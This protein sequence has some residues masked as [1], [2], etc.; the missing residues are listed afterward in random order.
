MQIAARVAALFGLLCI[1]AAP[2]PST[3]AP[4]APGTLQFS[5]TS[6]EVDEGTP[7]LVVAV[8]RTNGSDG[9]VAA[10]VSTSDI[11]AL[12]NQDYTPISV[13]VVFVDGDSTAKTISIPILDDTL[14]EGDQPLRLSL[15]APSGGALLGTHSTAVVTIIDDEPPPTPPMLSVSARIK[16]LRFSWT[17][18]VGASYYKLSRSDLGTPGQRVA[19]VPGNVSS[20][21]LDIAVHRLNWPQAR[22]RLSACNPQGCT[23][24]NDIDVVNQ[25]LGAIGYFKAS[26]T[27]SG[28]DFGS[29]V[30]LS[31]DGGTLAVG[32]D[33]ERSDATGID[34][35][36]N[37]NNEPG[38][39]AVYIFVRGAGG[40]WSQQ[41][42][43][44]A[45]SSSHQRFGSDVALS[46][47]G[48]TL[49]VGARS[50]SSVAL[51]SGA[52]YVFS[53]LATQWSQQALLRP[54]NNILDEGEFGYAVALSADGDTLAVGAR[55]EGATRVCA[56]PAPST[57]S[58]A[59]APRGR[60]MPT[61][62]PRT[63]R[64]TTFSEPPSPSVRMESRSL[65]A[66]RWNA[67]GP[68]ASTAIR[69]TIRATPTAPST[70]S[71][72]T[73]LNGRSRL[74]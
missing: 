4:T 20:T 44:K 64:P 33:Y 18:G 74:T 67:A 29:A 55:W 46:A 37:N 11:R 68:P 23:D 66:H 6:Y 62:T 49:A 8:T 19:I 22:Y 51:N 70:C 60:N 59:R 34:G 7:T 48:N 57:Y 52:V 5:A 30:A 47:D 63:S 72:A 42:Y 21:T 14:A 50:E 45:S 31:A 13:K 32:A 1:A 65:S 28:E 36:Q 10:R 54:S 40:Q 16:Q 38:A 26:N 43:V 71:N 17:G 56:A 9:K 15:E 3:A 12:A 41:A 53:R 25:M 58:H 39:G 61:C 73:P 2:L 24:S 69:P 27:E 35:D